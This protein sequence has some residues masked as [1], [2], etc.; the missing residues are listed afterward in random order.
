MSFQNSSNQARIRTICEKLDLLQNSATS[1]RATV[2]EVSALL[3]PVFA[4]LGDM[5]FIAGAHGEGANPEPH[6]IL[7]RGPREE[8]IP[9]AQLTAGQ[10]AALKLA[11]GASLK[12]L[13]AALLGRLEAHAETLGGA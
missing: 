8:P 12:D 6:A 1:N 9:D 11:N 3:L 13:C 2:E 5:G 10:R 7:E 4:K